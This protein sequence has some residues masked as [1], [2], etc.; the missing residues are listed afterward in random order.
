MEANLYLP[1]CTGRKL[2][3]LVLLHGKGGD[4]FQWLQNVLLAN[5]LDNLQRRGSIKPFMVLLP[6]LG[7]HEQK[8]GLDSFL[9]RELPDW[10]ETHG[11]SGAG[12]RA[13]EASPWEDLTPCAWPRHTPGPTL[14]GHPW[15]AG[16][17]ARSWPSPAAA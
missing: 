9:A 14:S 5:Y 7:P 2:P 6:A 3:S 10:L 12:A 17:P 4:N 11:R 8:P 15:P 13:S 1:P 16:S